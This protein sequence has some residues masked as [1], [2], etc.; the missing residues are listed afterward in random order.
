MRAALKGLEPFAKAAQAEADAAAAEAPAAFEAEDVTLHQEITVRHVEEVA[1]LVAVISEK[2]TKIPGNSMQVASQTCA[3]LSASTATAASKCAD[4]APATVPLA[5]RH[6]ADVAIEA[7]MGATNA[8]ALDEVGKAEPADG[9]AAAGVAE[10]PKRTQVV[11]QT[12]EE[13]AELQQQLLGLA[14]L[15]SLVPEVTVHQKRIVFGIV[16]E[17]F[18]HCF[19]TLRTCAEPAE[20]L[21]D[22]LDMQ[23]Q[24]ALPP[25]GAHPSGVLRVAVA[26]DSALFM[27]AATDLCN[28]ADSFVRPG[29]SGTQAVRDKLAKQVDSLCAHKPQRRPGSR[30][31][32]RP[33]SRA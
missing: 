11:V 33:A 23:V 1:R 8:I 25:G 30:Q 4:H 29:M 3:V 16:A 22:Y 5:L 27:K 10:R 2:L 15:P 21:S 14:S 6:A 12:N 32:S 13:L 17:H 19:R 31:S 24:W 28:R 18:E 26:I 9:D 20:V 7:A